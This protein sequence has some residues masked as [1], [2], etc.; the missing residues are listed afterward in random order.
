MM[1][2]ELETMELAD[3]PNITQI[4]QLL[5]D[6]K[7][8]YIVMEF[9]PGGDLQQAFNENQDKFVNEDLICSI[10]KQVLSTLHYLHKKEPEPVVHK[11]I[12]PANFLIESIDYALGKAHVKLTDFGFAACKSNDKVYQAKN[13]TLYYQ[14]PEFFVEGAQIS[15]AVDIWAAGVMAFYFLSGGQYPF[16]FDDLDDEDEEDFERRVKEE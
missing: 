4:L 10:I 2:S 12:K 15:N 11:D 3:H 6:N 8:M 9:V 7:N 1:R 14:A 5:E 13:G 16:E